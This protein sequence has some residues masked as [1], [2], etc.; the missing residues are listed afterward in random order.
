[1]AAIGGIEWQKIKIGDGGASSTGM[2]Q[3]STGVPGA[4]AT[5]LV[6]AVKPGVSVSAAVSGTVTVLGGVSVTVQQGVSVSAAVSGTVS[7]AGGSMS[8]VS[9][10]AAILGSVLVSGTVSALPVNQTT[11]APG[12]AATGEIAWVANPVTAVG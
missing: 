8:V 9:T 4:T 12:A 1:C 5:G 6:V 11:A 2:V 7:L 10:I 3:A